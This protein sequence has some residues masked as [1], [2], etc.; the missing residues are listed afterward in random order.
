MGG[1]V[2]WGEMGRTVK[3]I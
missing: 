1:A 2:K 3:V